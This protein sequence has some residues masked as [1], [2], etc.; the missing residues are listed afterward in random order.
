MEIDNKLLKKIL[1]IIGAALVFIDIFWG[2][3]GY[4]NRD[5]PVMGIILIAGCACLFIAS[6]IKDDKNNGEGLPLSGKWKC[7]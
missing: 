5:L 1:T 3:S 7:S 2:R 4:Y 6:K